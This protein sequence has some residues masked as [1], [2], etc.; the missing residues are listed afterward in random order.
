MIPTGEALPP[1][2]ARQWLRYCPQIPLVNAYGPTECSDDVT[3]YFVYAPPDEGVVNMSIGRPISNLRM[4]IL[5]ANRQPVPIGVAGEL[6]VGGVGVGRGYIHD[7]E[8]T[9]LAFVPDPFSADP[10]AR[11]YKTGD[12]ARYLPDGNIEYLGRLDYQVKLRGFRIELGEIEAVL[13]E[14]P[15]VRQA[16]VM[17][18]TDQNNS[19]Y[20]VAYLTAD[21]PTT[22]VDVTG[23]DIAGVRAFVKQR[24]P[25]YMVPALFMAL[26]TLPLTPNGKLDRKALPI[27]DGEIWGATVAY[28]APENALQATLVTIWAD[29]LKLA[30]TTIGIQH[31]FFELGGHSLL[32]GQIIAHVRTAFA[33]ELPIRELMENPTIAGMAACIQQRAQLDSV[34]PFGQTALPRAAADQSYEVIE[35]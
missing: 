20:L 10:H 23:L 4:Y 28:A 29:V 21:D 6:Y 24:L 11:L 13:E 30:P 27:P 17:D 8:R 14:H 26:E 7:P 9:A 34:L 5:D 2:L 32:A 15:A 12:K 33:V 19:K 1:N 18:R 3:H 31:S 35:L 22:A 25:E 16:V